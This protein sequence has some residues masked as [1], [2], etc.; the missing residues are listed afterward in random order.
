MGQFDTD[1]DAATRST[2]V[3]RKVVMA[4]SRDHR[5]ERRRRRACAPHYW[6]LSARPGGRFRSGIDAVI[7]RPLRM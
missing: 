6:T 4:R 2:I 7:S 3:S 5:R 1:L